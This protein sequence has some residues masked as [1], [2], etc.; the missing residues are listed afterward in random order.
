M[1]L[2]EAMACGLPVISTDT[3]Y[4]PR[5][6]LN[7]GDYGLLVPMHD[8]KKMAACLTTLIKNKAL[9]LSYAKKGKKR[10]RVYNE[11]IMLRRLNDLFKQAYEKAESE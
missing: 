3:P 11:K 6:I 5:E 4:G 7:G 10:S 8:Y 1:V 2:I 9:R